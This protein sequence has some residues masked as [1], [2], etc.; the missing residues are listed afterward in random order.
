M[1]MQLKITFNGVSFTGLAWSVLSE[2][3]K[4]RGT[5]ATAT[6]Y[7]QSYARSM[8]IDSANDVFSAYRR[9]NTWWAGG[10]GVGVV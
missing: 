4:G 6:T 2:F 5:F 8:A 7:P 9:D 3:D 10:T 1:I